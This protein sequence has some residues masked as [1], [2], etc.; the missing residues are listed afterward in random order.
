MALQVLSLGEVP[1]L[2][3]FHLLPIEFILPHRL[4]TQFVLYSQKPYRIKELG[5]SSLGILHALQP[6]VHSR[7]G[8]LWNQ[9]IPQ[10][11]K[12][13]EDHS[14]ETLNQKEW[15]DRLLQVSSPQEVPPTTLASFS[16]FRI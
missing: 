4:L 10:M 7:V 6:V 14:E 13:L 9:E 2:S 8:Q 11:L 5:A 15:E 12:I 3:N 16:L 1:N